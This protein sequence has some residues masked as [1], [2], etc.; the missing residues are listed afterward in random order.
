M[1]TLRKKCSVK[2]LDVPFTSK[3]RSDGAGPVLSESLLAYRAWNYNASVK[4]RKT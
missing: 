4:L 2:A 3:T 1:F